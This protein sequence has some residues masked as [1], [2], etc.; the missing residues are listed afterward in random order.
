MGAAL[1]LLGNV[2]RAAKA[3]HTTAGGEAPQLFQYLRLTS[4]SASP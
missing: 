3:A 2:G 4:L 1:T